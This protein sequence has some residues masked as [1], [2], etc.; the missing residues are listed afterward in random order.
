MVLLA[1]FGSTIYKLTKFVM[2]LVHCLV[3]NICQTIMGW[4]LMFIFFISRFNLADF[5]QGFDIALV[6]LPSMLLQFHSKLVYL[7]L[8][9]T[10]NTISLLRMAQNS[11]I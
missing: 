7:I 5:D 10:L 2:C 9:A 1:L 8:K 4:K 6:R 11:V 3:S